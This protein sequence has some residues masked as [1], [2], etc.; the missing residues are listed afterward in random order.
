MKNLILIV[1]ALFTNVS[2]GAIITSRP[3]NESEYTRFEYRGYDR[4]WTRNAINLR[5]IGN[6]GPI[7]LV[8]NGGL[9]RVPVVE[10]WLPKG[11]YTELGLSIQEFYGSMYFSFLSNFTRT[12]PETTIGF[13]VHDFTIYN[14][15]DEIVINPA[16]MGIEIQGT[17]PGSNG[18]HYD[19][20]SLNNVLTTHDFE[21]VIDGLAVTNQVDFR[22]RS[23]NV[24][25]FAHLPEPTTFVMSMV[26]VS[27]MF[28]RKG[29]K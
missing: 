8:G 22:F 26:L 29:N 19:Q 24:W 10:F 28:I 14:M 15:A 1:V 13:G 3:T 12:D 18:L 5:D 6:D 25:G 7:Q 16:R 21:Y 2:N 4:G 27:C 20:F 17:I 11:Q 23:I 9:S